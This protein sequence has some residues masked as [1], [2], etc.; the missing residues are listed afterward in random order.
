MEI[1]AYQK[2]IFTLQHTINILNW[3]LIIS[4]PPK[5]KD[6]VIALISSY[7]S[8][9]F[10]LK[11]SKE[12]GDI[13]KKTINSQEYNNLSDSEKRYINRLYK[14]YLQ[15]EKI[16]H[17]FYVKYIELIHK[18]TSVWEQAKENNDYDSFKP[19]LKDVIEATKTYY[20]YLN[21]G[22]N[23]YDTMLDSYEEG[24]TCEVIDK[25]FN[26]LKVKLIPLIKKLDD[27]R[28][29]YK[30]N[31]SKDVL[32]ETAKYLLNYIGFSM[33][34]GALGIYPHGFTE[35]IDNNDVRIA[36]KYTDNPFDFVTTII[37]EGG[38]GILEQNVDSKLTKYECTSCDGINALHE[39][40]SRF[41]EN[42]L[43]RNINFWYP[44]YDDVKKMLGLDMDIETFVK[45]LNCAIPSL[46]RTE[47]DELTYCMH[48]ILRYEIERELFNGSLSVDDLPKVW[49][50]KMQEY[51]GITPS[52]E[53]DGLLQD[54]HWAEG[55]FGY[56][57]S[58]LIGSIF[59][60]MFK[61]AIERDL[62]LIDEL[63]KQ[64]NIK[65]ITNYLIENIYVNGGAYT[66][67]EVL[68][69]LG[70][71]EITVE[72]LVKYFYEKYDK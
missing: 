44:I 31:S 27:K 45:G 23:L 34:K 11:T 46:V 67:C 52:K 8:N 69:K 70:F 21:K 60:G 42:I 63:L 71:K 64:G 3:D 38:H 41:F 66:G 35:K 58:Y 10:K 53:K 2:E 14:N 61:D 6:N 30:I 37:H 28:I 49:N 22:E 50:E 47:A 32:I 57:P 29:D 62:G 9:L 18:S 12:Y 7:E 24:L 33:D 16:P 48:I 51:F 17:D 26:E 15:S 68:E 19:Y 72:P 25:L 4:T 56:F 40:Q 65:K 43:G 54:I 5:E 1:D 13:L 55:A 39:S 36:F 20:S 59:D